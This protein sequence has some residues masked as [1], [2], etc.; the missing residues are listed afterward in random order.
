[1]SHAAKKVS[2]TRKNTHPAALVARVSTP[3]SGKM[4]N[5]FFQAKNKISSPNDAAEHEADNTAAKIMRMHVPQN[6]IA[7]VPSSK[8]GIFRQISE[9][10]DQDKVSAKFESPYIARFADV[11]VI[12]SSSRQSLNRQA[13]AEEEPVQRQAEEEEVQRQA[14]E[15]PVQRQAEEEEVQRQAEEEPL[16]RQ[17]DEEEVQR[18][19]EEEPVQ[20]QAEEQEVQRQAEEEPVQRQAEDE[21][22]QRKADENKDLPGNVGADIRNAKSAGTPL[23]LSVRKYMEPRFEA[24]FSHVR[25]HTD[26]RASQLNKQINAKA[27]ATSNHIFF[28]DGQFQP[29]TDDGKELLAH[30]LTHTIQQGAT[31]QRKEAAPTVS[32]QAGSGD[33]QRLGISDALDYFADKANYIPGFRM[34][35]VVLGINPINMSHVERSPGNILRAII[36]FIPGASFITQALDNHGVFDRVSTWAAKQIETL[37][38]I[39]SS[40]RESIN[41]FLDS[42]GWRDIFDLGD[43]WQRAKAIFTTPIDR[44]KRFASGLISG[45]ISIVK[46]VILRPLAQL[47]QST[48][49]EQ[50]Y[51]LL[52]AV[53]GY[54]PI[55]GNA[56]PRSAEVIIGGFM[57]LI[58]QEEVWNN[59]QQSNAIPRAWAWFQGALAGVVGF[60]T[61]LPGKFVAAF[62]AL[63]IE[64]I[65]LIPRALGKIIS[66]FGTYVGN[67]IS[68]AGGKV[69]GLLQ[70]I[71]AVVAP[72]AVPFISRA[73]GAFRSIIQNPIGFVGNLVRAGKR[74]FQKFASNFLGHL[75][76]SLI[77]WITGSMAGT[78]VYIPQ[79]FNLREIVKFVLSVMGLTWQNIRGKLVRVVGETAVGAMERG[80]EIVKTLVTEGPAAAWQQI[81]ESISNLKDM[82]ME[83]IMNFVAVRV[84]QAAITKLV[85][86]LN[87]AG[88]FIQAILAIYNTIMFFV[89]RLRQIGQVVASFVNSIAAIAAGNVAGA[90]ARVERTL[91]GMLTLVVSFL[92]RFA[93][94]GKVSDAITNIINRIRQ[95]ID[96]ALD[97]VVSWIVT[98]ARRLGR[99]VAQAG[100]PQEYS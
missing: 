59:L 8:G 15:E 35:T 69:L 96:K 83:Q 9:E 48:I 88:A 78:G 20:R 21:E 49:G 38:M 11:P 99:F 56:V 62:L 1:M 43:V 28:A 73:A 44:I 45:I 91:A 86:S 52:T 4:T 24:N 51:S 42:L 65:I 87:P 53:L 66:V 19:A 5:G 76:D 97:K 63:S 34:F 68:W 60:V 94:L 72:G 79:G 84:V 71:F 17:A 37:G 92:A 82:V 54:D 100:V 89:E 41:Q 14:E 30:E 95:P 80:F 25:I 26:D 23:P 40:I 55:T 39:G 16:Q 29:E 77:G 64:D 6:N 31:V 3:E 85:T 2:V 47:A 67:F 74:G 98:Q 13:Q 70:I 10:S 46:E 58:G 61:G 93:G 22:V 7:F 57:R 33:V 90:A 27:F 75:K 36:E 12:G 32:Q 81:V 50:N 18:Q